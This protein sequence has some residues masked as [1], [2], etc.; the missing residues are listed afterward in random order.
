MDKK[1]SIFKNLYAP[2]QFIDKINGVELWMKREDLIHKEV[3]GNKWRKLKYF[4]QDFNQN[5]KTE[6]LSFGGAYS[7]HILALASLGNQLGL[8]TRGIIRGEEVSNPTLD[9]CEEMGMEILKISR[10]D[11]KKR[12]EDQFINDLKERFPM[13]Y[14]IPEGGKDPLGMLGCSEIMKEID[15]N[16][17]V[18]ACSSGTGTTFSGLLASGFNSK[19]IMFPALKGAEFLRKDI[20]DMFTQFRKLFLTNDLGKKLEL[21][22]FYMEKNYHFG[23]YG[24]VKEELIEFMNDFYDSYSIPLD[25]VYTGKML[26]GLVDQIKKDHFPKGSKVLCIHTGGLQGIRGMN[27]RLD[28][29][30]LKTLRYEV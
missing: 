1:D 7:N 26:F 15:P 9:A 28:Q 20:E 17:D 11:Y 8:K 18:V 16:F 23:G 10:S 25:P 12:D 24:K 6:I 30:G 2:L 27:E 13:A 14:F 19:F 29:K 5:E 4:L 3:S 22:E 21:P